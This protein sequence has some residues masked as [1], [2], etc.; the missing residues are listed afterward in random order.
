[1]TR[2]DACLS[3][4]LRHEGGYVDHPHDPG[5]ATNMG[6][7]HITLADWRG[8]PVTKD[9]VRE[10]TRREAAAIY[11]ANYWNRVH[12]D[13]LPAGL[14]L[15]VFDF[16]VNSGVARAARHLQAAVGVDRDGAIGPVTLAAV[17]RRD[18]VV[19]MQA[20]NGR[21]LD[22][23]RGLDT[24]Q[25]FGRGWQRRVNEIT[26]AATAMALTPVAPAPAVSKPVWWQGVLAWLLSR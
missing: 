15:A 1:M 4:V 24:W 10:L 6:I 22:F 2:F 13:E 16:A 14:D 9:D 17:A 23:L 7:T 18:A 26:A 3:H 11:R 21:R 19:L 20:L 8:G 25:H 12:G 5:G